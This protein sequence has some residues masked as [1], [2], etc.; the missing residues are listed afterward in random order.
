MPLQISWHDIAI[1]L[2]LTIV[3]GGLIGIN[4]EER[5]QAAGLRTTI[6]VC[7]AA[8]VSMI[9]L[10]FLLD[11][12]GKAQN[13]FVVMDVMRLPLGILSGMGFI[14]GGVILRKGSMVRGVTTAA[15]LWFV[16]VMGLCFGGGQ[17][18]LGVITLVLGM[19]ILVGLKELEKH[20]KQD[21]QATL[22]LVAGQN[23]PSQSDIT[24]AIAGAGFKIVSSSVTMGENS[25]LAEMTCE[26]SWRAR[27]DDSDQPIIFLKEIGTRF[28]LAKVDWRTGDNTLG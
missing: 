15:T 25:T 24:L 14:G 3:G 16:T 17:I 8:S 11:V 7:L 28:G 5:G 13:S 1:R 27:H 6:L 2:L 4:R 26:V 18:G 19:V 23:R 12:T 20:L 22:T 21:R 10:N 9:Q